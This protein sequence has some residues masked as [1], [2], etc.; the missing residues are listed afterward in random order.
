MSDFKELKQIP[1]NGHIGI[2]PVFYIHKNKEMRTVER[3]EVALSMYLDLILSPY[4]LATISLKPNLI[5]K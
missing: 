3:T 4:M 2:S 5:F 1:S